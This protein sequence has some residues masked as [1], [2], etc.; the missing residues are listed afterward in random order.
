MPMNV[1]RVLN[2]QGDAVQYITWKE[3]YIV[4]IIAIIA[5]IRV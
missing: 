5:I 3:N 4:A 1:C 2:L